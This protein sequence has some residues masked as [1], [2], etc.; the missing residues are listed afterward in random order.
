MGMWHRLLRGLQLL[1]GLGPRPTAARHGPGRPARRAS[2]GDDRPRRRPARRLA[3]LPREARPPG[4]GVDPA[5]LLRGRF[6]QGDGRGVR[7]GQPDAVQPTEPAPPQALQLRAASPR[8]AGVADMSDTPN[9]RELIEDL[10]LLCD[11]RLDADRFARLQGRLKD[12]PGAQR[13]YLDY[14]DTHLALE[15]LLRPGRAGGVS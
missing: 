3:G 12:D 13:I 10:E 11:G 6:G 4:A 1:A 5:R 2:A 9:D 7:P 15:R 14:V 8:H